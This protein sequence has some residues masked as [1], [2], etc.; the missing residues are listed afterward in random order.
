MSYKTIVVQ[1]DDSRHAEARIATAISI[2][3]AQEAHLIGMAVTGV[4]RFLYDTLTVAPDQT[5]ITPHVEALRQRAENALSKF[6]RITREAG[7]TSMEKLMVDDEAGGGFTLQA[8]CADIVVMGQPQENDPTATT[9]TD[10]AEYVVMNSGVPGL[11]VP[12]DWTA[13]KNL[14]KVLISWNA[15][16]EATRA[17]HSAIPLLRQARS[18]QVVMFNLAAQPRAQR[19][20]PGGGIDIFLARHGIKVALVQKDTNRPVGDALLSHATEME[21]DLLIMGCYGHSRFREILLGGATRTIL[22]A[23]GIPV[24]M[25]H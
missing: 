8:R 18:V 15:S 22:T 16:K 14:D 5:D 4:S 6:E 20:Q 11:I 19:M 10:F 24:L 12:L 1:V 17:L 9:S 7:V 3:L 13:R 25:A 2:A 23:A 21:A